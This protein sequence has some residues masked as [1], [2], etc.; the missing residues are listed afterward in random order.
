MT[1]FIDHL[2][3]G[4]PSSTHRGDGI[5]YNG[6]YLQTKVTQKVRLNDKVVGLTKVDKTQTMIALLCA[7]LMV[8]SYI[9]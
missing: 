6:R 2:L 7:V 3:Q 4:W 8:T 9:L 1:L 5:H